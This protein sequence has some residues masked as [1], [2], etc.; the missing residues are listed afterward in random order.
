MCGLD[1]L[2]FCEYKHYM[3]CCIKTYINKLSIHEQT[4]LNV[5]HYFLFFL[6]CRVM[7][8]LIYVRT[9]ERTG[10][11]TNERTNEWMDWRVHTQAN[12]LKCYRNQ[13][14]IFSQI[15]CTCNNLYLP[16]YTR[17]Y[18]T[19]K[20]ILGNNYIAEHFTRDWTFALTVI[21]HNSVSLLLHTSMLQKISFSKLS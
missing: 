7:N 16:R 4:N 9:N 3:I 11:H 5:I 6:S 18:Q 17:L 20:T 13:G 8:Q 15:N 10:D 14:N 2:L 21:H 1:S 12:E 19:E